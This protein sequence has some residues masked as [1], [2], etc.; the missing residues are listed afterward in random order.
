[1]IYTLYKVFSKIFANIIRYGEWL[2]F[3][4]ILYQ[5]GEASR[6]F[7]IDYPRCSD[8]NPG[9][10]G[11]ELIPIKIYNCPRSNFARRI[12][13]ILRNWIVIKFF[14]R[15]LILVATRI[16]Y[17]AGPRWEFESTN[18]IF[19]IIR[20]IENNSVF[21]TLCKWNAQISKIERV[22]VCKYGTGEHFWASTR[23]K[24]YV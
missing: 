9:S 4:Q 24:I 7:R 11:I 17:F 2:K 23:S 21:E 5:G 19:G 6:V 18:S 10:F 13:F 16:H 20:L 22:F 3:D 15:I 1:M 12:Y 14:G 8:I